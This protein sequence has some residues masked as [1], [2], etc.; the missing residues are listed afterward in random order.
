MTISVKRLAFIL[1]GVVACLQILG[2][3]AVYSTYVM[4][5][6]RLLGLIP[7]IQLNHEGNIPT[8]YSVIALMLA[9]CFFGLIWA[10]KKQVSGR[11]TRHWGLMSLLFIYIS[12]DEAASIHE[13]ISVM[14]RDGL[15]ATGFLYYTWVV[16]A[17]IIVALLG[18]YYIRFLLALP[19]RT[20]LLLILSAVMYVTGAAGLEVLEAGLAFEE[21]RFTLGYASL[22]ATEEALE[23]L[24]IV[25]LNFSLADYIQRE[26]GSITIRFTA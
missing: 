10:H 16:P 5:H 14:L 7:L 15:G 12:M 11:F 2:W 23:M 21:G 24:G 8:W 9:A 3:M 6:G 18:L 22:A 1:V 20:S 26:M 13:K 25:L 17:L 4:G 19:R